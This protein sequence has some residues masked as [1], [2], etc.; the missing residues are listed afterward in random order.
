M[1]EDTNPDYPGIKVQ[2]LDAYEA[3]PTRSLKRLDGDALKD[4]NKKFLSGVKKPAA[5]AAAKPAGKP[6]A[7]PAP[8]PADS[9]AAKPAPK[10]AAAPPAKAAPKPV[11]KTAP[12]AAPETVSDL[13]AVATQTQAWELVNE[14]KGKHDDTDVADAWLAA[15]GRVEESSKRAEDA[16]TDE[17]WAAVLARTLDNLDNP[18]AE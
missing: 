5:A 9:P 18:Q 1:A 12:E 8:K 17:D 13:P 10:P 11:P 6:A 4:L 16:F 2:W 3:S 7:K 14:R 15:I